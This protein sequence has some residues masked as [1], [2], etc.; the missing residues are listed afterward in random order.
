MLCS[1][2]RLLCRKTV[3][4]NSSTGEC[5]RTTVGV[6]QGCRFSPALYNDFIERIMTHNVEGNDKKVYRS[7]GNI[8]SLRF[9]DAI[10]ALS[11]V[12][13]DV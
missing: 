5:L 2:L 8:T 7:G 3:Q 9:A 12:K 13:I 4:M 6:G 1:L 10:D 11:E